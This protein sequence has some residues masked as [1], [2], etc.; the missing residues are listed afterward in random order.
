VDIVAGASAGG[1]NGIQ[2]AR[3]LVEGHDLDAVTPLWLD[4]ADS[5]VL[6]DARAAS[7]PLSK[8]WAIPLVWWVRR[9]GLGVE[10]KAEMAAHAEV[11]RKLSRFMRSRWFAP[12]FSGATFTR[13]LHDGF[14]AMAAGVRLPPL[15]PRLH[16]FDLFVTVTDYQGSLEQLRLNSPPLVLEPEHRLTIGFTCPG[17]GAERH[18]GDTPSLTLAARATASFPGAFP[19]ARVAEVDAL[20]AAKGLTWPGRADFLARNF[21]GRSQPELVTLLDGAILDNRPFGPAIAALAG[22]PAHREVDRRFVYIDPKPGMH[23]QGG[24]DPAAEPGWFAAILRSLAD[25]PRQQ[26]IKDNLAQI[27]ALSAKVRRLRHIILGMLPE[28]DAAIDAAIGLKMLWLAPTPERLAE[29]RSRLQGEAARRAGFAFAAYGRLKFAMV[30]D[31]VAAQLADLGG[32]PAAAVRS[33]LWRFLRTHGINTPEQAQGRDG[34]ASDYVMFLRRFDVDF[35]IRRL[36]FLIRRINLAVEASSSA[37]ERDAL[38]AAKAGLYAILGP[39]LECRSRARLAGAV[40][41]AADAAAQPGAALD[42]LAAALDLKRLDDGSDAALVALL[43]PAMPRRLRRILL[44]AY[45]GFPFFDIAVLPLIADGGVDELD[46]IKVDR[47]SPADCSALT[48]AGGQQLKGAL[49][50][51]FGAFFSRAWRSHDY[52][53]G[54]LHGAERMIDLVISALPAAAR[55]DAAVL[56]QLRRGAFRAIL[57]AERERLSAVPELLAAL[58]AILPAAP[59]PPPAAAAG[60]IA[61]DSG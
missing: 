37:T 57:V 32:V 53:W 30:A 7:R 24:A 1:I 45:L 6:L 39:H 14:E 49:F 60:D 10:D 41:A 34:A 58:E 11:R 50:N 61:A 26:P 33:S 16:P 51:A 59:D 54:R 28:V 21:P 52:L 8:L 9:R 42:A 12:P 27:E 25:I 5:D 46:E 4:Q 36:R 40:A 43:G 31:G 23:E 47:I 17:D 19:P 22:R 35:R 2:L 44:A 29:W 20:L 48:V 56:G 55:P 38:E 18:M 13:L 3:A 15:V